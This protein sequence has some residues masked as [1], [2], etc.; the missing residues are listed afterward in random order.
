[1]LESGEFLRVGETKTIKVN[2][3]IIAATNRDLQQDMDKGSFRSD[4][5]YRLSVFQIKLPA[6]RERIVDIELLIQ[7]F[8]KQ[9]SAKTGK[10]IQL[11]NP[12]FSKP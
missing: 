9:F 6:L 10:N 12:D 2:V 4:L 1:M 8:V 7:L 11:I 5:F 3:R